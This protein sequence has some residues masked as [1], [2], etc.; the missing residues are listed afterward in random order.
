[1]SKAKI[2]PLAISVFYNNAG[3]DGFAF[4]FIN[5]ETAPKL[6]Q[7]MQDAYTHFAQPCQALRDNNK[8]IEIGRAH[9]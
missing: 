2:I 5:Q 6:H 1:M 8:N 7:A 9:V 3:N 4:L